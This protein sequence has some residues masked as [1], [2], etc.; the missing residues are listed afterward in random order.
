MAKYD[1]IVIG[2]GGV[3]SAAMYQLSRRGNSVLGLDRHPPGHD[4][5]SSHGQTRVIRQA[6]FEHPDY[7][8]LLRTVYGQWAE[9]ER[10]S[11]R[12]L[13]F[14]VGLL[15]VGPADGVVVPGVLE[16]K[17]EHD[18]AVDELTADEAQKLFPQFYIPPNC[19]AVFEREAGYLLVEKSVETMIELAIAAGSVHRHGE[20]VKSWRATATA[21]VVETDRDTYE[22]A[23]LVI[24]AGAWA[25]RLLAELNIPFCICRKHLHWFESQPSHSENASPNQTQPAYLFEVDSGIYYGFPVSDGSMKV[26]EHTRGTEIKDP[27]DDD[28]SPEQDDI[29]RVTKFVEQHLHQVSSKRTD[30]SVCFYTKSP[31][32][33]FI[34]D[35]HPLHDN[36]AIVAGL[37]G[38]GYKFTPVLGQI[39]ADLLSKGATEL[40]IQFLSLNRF[41]RD[42]DGT[43]QTRFPVDEC[44]I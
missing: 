34:V 40:P 15:E 26:G 37:S 22:A 2:T 33:H 41:C 7:V 8:P 29:Q 19:A 5:G 43:S 31:D 30:H 4:Q 20:E 17:R 14:P 16:S 6:Y 28:R 42:N 32:C 24:S 13:Y 44:E 25:N 38:H 27:Q 11:K 39:V 3:G 1:V 36:V 10:E 21:V 12:Q 35:R 18:L 23:S 9:L